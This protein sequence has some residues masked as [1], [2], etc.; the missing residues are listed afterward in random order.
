MWL[1]ALQGIVCVSDYEFAN[2][3]IKLGEKT[4]KIYNYN[5]VKL[6]REVIAYVQVIP[7]VGGAMMK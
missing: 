6:F 1:N 4:G 5:V 7:P 2:T 3:L